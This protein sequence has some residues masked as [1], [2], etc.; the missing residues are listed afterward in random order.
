MPSTVHHKLRIGADQFTGQ[1]V[2]DQQFLECDFSG[3]DLTATQFVNCVFYDADTRTGC[4]FSG[5]TLKEASFRQC[6]ISMCNFNFIKVGAGNQRMPRTGCRFQQ[7]QFHEP[8]HHAQLVLQCL[9][10]EE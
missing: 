3:A 9:H 10:Q 8:D 5:A 1:K 7:R 6:D 4:R 2:V